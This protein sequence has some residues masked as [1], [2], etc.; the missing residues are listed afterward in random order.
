MNGPTTP[1]R[2]A[3]PE[4]QSVAETGCSL[5][6]L[7]DLALKTIYYSGELSAQDLCDQMKL[8][9]VN[10]IQAVLDFLKREELAVI[11]GGGGYSEQGLQYVVTSNG[12]ERA[13]EALLRSQYVGPAPVGLEE[14]R[15]LVRAQSVANLSIGPEEVHEAFQHLVL[16]REVVD[17]LGPAVNSGRAVF[18][19]G[20]PGSGKSTIAEAMRP[21]LGGD[22]FVPY[23]VNAAGHIIRVYDPQTH[24]EVEQRA[25]GQD[26]GP[27]SAAR[28][29]ARWVRCRRPFVQVGGELTLNALDLNYDDVAKYYE[30]PLQM[31]ANGG[32][33]LIDD[34]GRQLVRP[35]DLLNRWM[36]P[37][38]KRLDYLTLHTGQKVE[39]PFDELVVF[40]TNIE[41]RE[42]VDEAFLR[43]IRHKVEA[44]GPSV[45]EFRL[46]MER[47]CAD[48]RIEFDE[49]VFNY[50]VQEHYMNAEREMRGVHP[51]DLMDQI[52]DISK[53]RGIPPAMT[54]DLIDDACRS[55][56]VRV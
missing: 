41:P 6:F 48:R 25:P 53:Y 28:G 5:G 50:L 13:R 1:M 39:I 33:L 19:Y 29:D 45:E 52:I 51:R 9:F 34:F 46:I 31:R 54:E 8:P 12:A 47:V 42:L 18:I 37:L 32:M 27:Q 22:I 55:Y 3:P 56:F 2:S 10:V 44:V 38:E 20:E 49:A 40:S 15:T 14:Y 17:A 23:A 35:A 4:P 30:A 7:A 43:R 24:G 36:V 21:L 16:S 11:S 26:S